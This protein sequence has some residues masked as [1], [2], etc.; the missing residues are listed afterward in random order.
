MQIS[1]LL[2]KIL[3]PVQGYRLYRFSN[4]DGKVWLMPAR[5]MRTA[6]NLYQPSGRNGKLLKALFPSL[7]VLPTVRRALH[8]E[9]VDCDLNAELRNLLEHVFGCEGIEF[10]L[11]CGT[12]CV[13]QKLTMQLSIGK[14]ILGYCKITGS[15]ELVQLFE[16][17]A[18]TLN[19]LHK[20]GMTG[21]PRC[22]FQGEWKNGVHLFVQSTVKSNSSRV[23]HH[24]SN[25]HEDF[26]A[27][28]Q[29]A[30]AVTVKFEESDYYRTLCRLKEH[31][32]WLPSQE[33]QASV[34]K[35][36]ESVMNTYNG[37]QCEFMAYHAD[38]TPWNMFVEDGELFVFDWEYAQQSYPPMLDR[39]HFFTQT[40]IFEKHWGAKEIISYMSSAEGAWADAEK[41]N[42]YLLDIIS[43]FT[44]REKG[45]ICGDMVKSFSVWLELLDC[46]RK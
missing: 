22:L 36:I 18:N 15:A 45:N 5:N 17:E 8:A 11:F 10:S 14:K 43:R 7:H 20:N 24:W 19:K 9:T 13:H 29:A 40:A 6:M 12:P 34:Q 46:L 30:S 42:L 35:A 2:D 4:A 41:Y 33:S 1:T 21:I 23:L 38:F 31:I 26:L 3:E 37:K 39:Y 27:R 28:L 32:D 44:M 16:R 25:L